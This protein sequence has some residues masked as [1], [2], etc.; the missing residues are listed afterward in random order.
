M[1]PL[2]AALLAPAQA[3][4][5]SFNQCSNDD[6][7]PIMGSAGFE[8]TLAA[9][10]TNAAT[11]SAAAFVENKGLRR[12]ANS[13]E[14][15]VVVG[16][17]AANL[18]FGVSRVPV[19]QE[20]AAYG[21][22]PVDYIL[23]TRPIDLQAY[24][25]GLAFRKGR[26]GAFYAASVTFGYPGEVAGL[27]PIQAFGGTM[28]APFVLP[29]LP[30]MGSFA[31]QTGASA[32][33]QDFVLGAIVDAEVADI[34]A[35]YTQSRGWYASALQ[36]HSGFF[37]SLV[38]RDGLSAVGQLRTGLERVPMPAEL[39]TKIGRP[40]LF[41]RVL[42]LTDAIPVRNNAGEPT[43]ESEQQNLVS[44][45][46]E[47]EGIAEVIDVRAAYAVQPVA[48]LREASV[49]FHARNFYALGDATGEVPGQLYVEAGFVRLPDQWYYGL[50]GGTFVQFRAQ[51]G[52][53]FG[54]PEEG[55]G[56]IAGG[57]QF[58]D[59]EQTALYPF[60]RNA[61]TFHLNMSGN[62]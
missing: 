61:L 60:A 57:V 15:L 30:V 51:Y 36:P 7:F 20:D 9:L 34:R 29:L 49:A 38:L 39:E 33:A 55:G 47:L 31:M 41:A 21:G 13:D 43:G 50:E 52:V 14:D 19:F 23:A 48:D 25:M 2:L 45:H 42:P 32:Y 44:G 5:A 53:P 8:N 62:F 27:R 54:D 35:G 26:F 40:S 1:I 11:Y 10:R 24:N 18:T 59:P 12:I 3:Q 16:E 58:N 6:A 46:A 28:V 22:C 17:F 56:S 37:G 4:Q